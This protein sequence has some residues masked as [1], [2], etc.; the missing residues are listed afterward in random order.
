MGG[1]GGTR[2]E[3]AVRATATRGREQV[4]AQRL[5]QLFL[6]RE[7]NYRQVAERVS[8]QQ[9]ICGGSAFRCAAHGPSLAPRTRTPRARR[10]SRASRGRQMRTSEA[11]HLAVLV[12]WR[13]STTGAAPPATKS[14]SGR[15]ALSDR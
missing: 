7:G 4:E 12:C 9:Q 10:A 13:A 5:P 1:G 14:Y 2:E 15:R 8:C 11:R 3:I 6:L